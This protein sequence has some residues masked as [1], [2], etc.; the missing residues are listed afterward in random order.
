MIKITITGDA[1]SGKS[2][3]ARIIADRLMAVN[4]FVTMSVEDRTDMPTLA[5]AIEVAR[6]KVNEVSIETIQS[7][8]TSV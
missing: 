2:S 7:A 6:H 4:V 8:R 5:G 3:I 1:G